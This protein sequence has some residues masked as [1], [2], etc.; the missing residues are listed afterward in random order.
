MAP[1]AVAKGGA[2]YQSEWR[3]APGPFKVPILH[4]STS[5]SPFSVFLASHE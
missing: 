5:F 2:E 4:L 1:T 3:G